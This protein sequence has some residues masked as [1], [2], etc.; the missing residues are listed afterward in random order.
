MF[1]VRLLSS[2]STR[3]LSGAGV[4]NKFMNYDNCSC[5]M[6]ISFH[7]KPQPSMID[8]TYL[9]LCIEHKIIDQYMKLISQPRLTVPA[10][11]HAKF[12]NFFITR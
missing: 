7:F 1:R 6:S 11:Q 4:I 3:S 5:F 9:N 12:D 10:I 8:D 2:T